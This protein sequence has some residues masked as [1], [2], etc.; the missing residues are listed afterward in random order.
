MN[1][2]DPQVGYTR[3][4]EHKHFAPW[5]AHAESICFR[6]YSR[7]CRPEDTPYYPVHLLEDD[8]LL[9]QYRSRAAAERNVTFVG[10][11]GTYQYLD[12]DRCIRMALDT[13]RASGLLNP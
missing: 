6:E 9:D 5:E 3:V 2:C 8:G 1:Y 10:R 7:H 4:T 13:V 11:L 12:M